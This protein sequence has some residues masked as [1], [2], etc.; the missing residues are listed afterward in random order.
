MTSSNNKICSSCG[1]N[2]NSQV[3]YNGCPNYGKPKTEWTRASKMAHTNA[4]PIVSITAWQTASTTVPSTS[5][6][7]KK[8]KWIISK[9]KELFQNDIIAGKDANNTNPDTVHKSNEEYTKWPFPNLKTN[10]KILLEAVALDNQR[11]AE[12]C[13]AYGHDINSLLQLQEDDEPTAWHQSEANLFLF[14]DIFSGKH[15]AMRRIDYSEFL[16]KTF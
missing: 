2:E 4:S 11:M 1:A 12:Y 3:A 7:K 6:A 15:R 8:T 9:A 13:K 14:I 10:I 5:T 16:L